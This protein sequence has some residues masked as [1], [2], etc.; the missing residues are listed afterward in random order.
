LAQLSIC[1]PTYNRPDLLQ[2]TLAS[3]TQMPPPRASR[4]EI[5]VSDNSADDRSATITARFTQRWPGSVVYHQNRPGISMVENHN[6]CIALA[7][8]QWVQF[9]HDDDY[10]L[11][12]GLDNLLTG[13]DRAGSR[14]RVLLFGVR[15]V[16]HRGRRLRSQTFRQDCVLPPNLALQR[17]LSN[18]SFVRMPA[19]V[20][21]CDAYAEVGLFDLNVGHRIDIVM[22]IRLFSA[23]G[24]RLLPLTTSAYTIHP[25]ADSF[26]VCNPEA[27]TVLMR[28]FHDIVPPGMLPEST[29]QQCQAHFFHQFVLAGAFRRLRVGDRVGARKIMELFQMPEVRRLGWSRRWAPVRM[30]FAT[31]CIGVRA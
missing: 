31:A 3:V 1:I 16:D 13:L 14:D 15:V 8:G 30:A 28:I 19:I 9:L 23:Y 20:V 10:L 27:I 12:G 17:L 18:S 11:P 2:R 4:V 26:A 25:A 24:V 29:V 22:W 7:T 21:R 6:R 5:I